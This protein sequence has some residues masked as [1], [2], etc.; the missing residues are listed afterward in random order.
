MTNVAS[1]L[2]RVC[3]T[4]IMT[5]QLKFVFCRRLL[6]QAA[7]IATPK[8]Y[9]AAFETRA[10]RCVS[11][12]LI[13]VVWSGASAQ[14]AEDGLI[15]AMQANSKYN[16]GIVNIEQTLSRHSKSSFWGFPYV[17][18]ILVEP[19]DKVSRVTSDAHGPPS[20][21]YNDCARQDLTCLCGNLLYAM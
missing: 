11:P 17:L 16:P 4:H 21:R 3:V 9:A 6:D 14:E 8:E 20:K 15:G 19:T 2:K 5:L 12:N 18:C 7:C 1:H 13:F 10:N